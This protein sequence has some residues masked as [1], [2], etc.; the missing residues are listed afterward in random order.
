MSNMRKIAEHNNAPVDTQQ[1]L[2]DMLDQVN[3]EVKG[4]LDSTSVDVA[5]ALDTKMNERVEA[6]FKKHWNDQLRA[7]V[8]SRIQEE[9]ADAATKLGKRIGEL[10]GKRGEL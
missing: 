7:W 10:L 4:G 6:A 3:E 5:V 2:K 1:V 8:E 9:V